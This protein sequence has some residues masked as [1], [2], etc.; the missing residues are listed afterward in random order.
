MYVKWFV[1]LLLTSCLGESWRVPPENLI[2]LSVWSFTYV[3]WVVHLLWLMFPVVLRESWR[4]PPEKLILTLFIMFIM[5]TIRCLYS[6]PNLSYDFMD[7]WLLCLPGWVWL[8][9]LGL[10][11]FSHSSPSC[12]CCMNNAFTPFT[13]CRGHKSLQI[14]ILCTSY[15]VWFHWTSVEQYTVESTLMRWTSSHCVTIRFRPIPFRNQ[16]IP[17]RTH[18]FKLFFVYKFKL[19][20]I[21]SWASDT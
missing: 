8:P 6:S 18:I 9:C 14:W 12:I 3:K 20:I 5:S 19:V 7:Y 16:G 11:L 13:K 2:S 4:V 17:F 15:S 21:S 10:I 1:Y